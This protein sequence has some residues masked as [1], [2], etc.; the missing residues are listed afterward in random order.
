[1]QRCLSLREEGVPKTA[2]RF[3]EQ[4]GGDKT[5]MKRIYRVGILLLTAILLA[6]IAIMQSQ[7]KEQ[8]RYETSFFDS[9]D[10]MTVITGY[11]KSEE[12]FEIQ[13]K[14]LQEKLREYHELFDIYHTYEGINNIKTIND[15]AGKEPVKVNQEL[16]K[17]LKLGVDMYGK[18]EGRLN[19]AYG[20]VLSVWHEYR[21]REWKSQNMLSCR[22]RNC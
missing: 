7:N 21:G 15:A 17:L 2:V 4:K 22:Q 5:L 9:F 6:G 19:I 8:K 18:T 12:D 14:K 13:A 1:M 10:T 3:Q 16:I 20:S 11:A